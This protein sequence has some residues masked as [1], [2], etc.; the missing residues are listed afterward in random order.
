[1]G[2]DW[3]IVIEG[4]GFFKV[5]DGMGNEFYICVGNFNVNLEGNLVIG[6]V[7][8]GWFVDLVVVIF[9]DMID[10]RIMEDGVIMII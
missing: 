10:V 6:L 5:V 3:D 1:M 2:C 9:F 4:D 8:I 7:N